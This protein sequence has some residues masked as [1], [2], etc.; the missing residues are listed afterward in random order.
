MKL[1]SSIACLLAGTL[2]FTGCAK[3]NAPPAE[4]SS[5][6]PV[7]VAD[8]QSVDYAALD[9]Q[10]VGWGQGTIVDDAN[11]PVS[12]AQFSEKYHAYEVLFGGE[13]RDAPTVC[14]TFDEGY[15]NGCTEQILDILKQKNCPA[16]FFVTMDYV[17]DRPDLVRRMIDEGH[18]VGNHTTTHPSMPSVSVE[19]LKDEILTLHDHVKEQFGYEMTLLRPP[20][21]EF[22][23]RTLAITKDLG[24]TTVLWSFAYKDWLTDAQPERDA[25]LN[26]MLSAAH[27]DAIYLLHAV[28]QTNTAVLGD[29]IDGMRQKGYTFTAIP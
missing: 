4:P 9:N 19:Q 1:Y 5:S 26:K 14:L 29:F 13:D 20:K 22:S 24:Y 17:K 18:T 27:N 10:T 2:L 8:R 7:V 28:S 25:A 15:E 12:C 23:T 11:C 6:E 3:K 21:G 16:V